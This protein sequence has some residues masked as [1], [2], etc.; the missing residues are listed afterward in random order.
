MYGTS[1]RAGPWQDSLGAFPPVVARR[2]MY[3]TVPKMPSPVL[4]AASSRSH[5]TAVGSGVDSATFRPTTVL[6]SAACQVGP[7]K[8]SAAR[9]PSSSYRL[10]LGDWNAHRPP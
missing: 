8:C 9:L 2:W 7:E 1:A 5:G 10:A 4:D 3:L 6:P